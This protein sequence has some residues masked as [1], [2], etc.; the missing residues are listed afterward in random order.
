ML[1][2][3]SPNMTAIRP[4][5]TYL[6][7][8]FVAFADPSQIQFRSALQFSAKRMILA[9]CKTASNFAPGNSIVAHQIANA[10]SK[11]SRASR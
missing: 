2:H 4:R 11:A 1:R 5:S 8:G 3:H 6:T 7:E 9:K 10:I